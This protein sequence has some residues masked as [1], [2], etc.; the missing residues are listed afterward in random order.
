MR[1]SRA[2]GT[3]TQSPGRKGG[4]PPH[5]VTDATRI[6]VAAMAS[7]GSTQDTIATVLRCDPTT[8][9]R[10]YDHELTHGK[11]IVDAKIA[12]T[13]IGRAIAGETAQG[14]FY[15]K[16]RMGWKES[17]DDAPS[18][19]LSLRIVRGESAEPSVTPLP[20]PGVAS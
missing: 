15:A 14:I 20:E 9:R 2:R 3:G 4:K 17:R 13:L 8:L 1:R 5:K 6:A 12:S 10:H 7:I 18:A 16:T 19:T 11:A